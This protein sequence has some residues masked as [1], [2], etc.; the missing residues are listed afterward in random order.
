M[1]F[2]VSGNNGGMVVTPDFYLQERNK[3]NVGAGIIDSALSNEEYG[4]SISDTVE[5]MVAAQMGALIPEKQSAI[6]NANIQQ[7]ALSQFEATIAMLSKNTIKPL[8]QKNAL[9]SYEISNSNPN[10]IRAEISKTGA[11]GS[12]D[13]SIGLDQLAQSQSLK[14]SGFSSENDVL[15][16]GT[17]TIYFGQYDGG[18][19]TE[20]ANSGSITVEIKD[21]MTLRDLAGEINKLSK[22]IKAT[23]VTNSDGST[24]LALISQKTGQQNAMMV[25]TSGDPSLTTFDY[26]GIDSST[27]TQVRETADAIY[28][29]NGIQMTSDTN[30]I[31]D[32]FG[33]NL[34]LNEV[35]SGEVRIGTTVSPQG[36]I[37]NVYA[38]VENYNAMIDMYNSFNSKNPDEDFVGSINGSKVSDAI[39]DEINKLFSDGKSLKDIGVTRDPD[40]RLSLNQ[41]KLGA[42]LEL[43]PE[44]AYEILGTTTKSSHTGVNI[45]DLGNSVNG[46][47]TIVITRAPEKANLTG[48]ALVPNNTIAADTDLKLK[49][50]NKEVTIPI[51]AGDYTPGQLA[52]TINKE[53]NLAG[54]SGYKASIDGGALSINSAEYGSLKSIELLSDVPELGLVAQKVTGKD[55]AGTINGESFLGDGAEFESKFE[56]ASKGMKVTFDPE[57]ITLNQQITIST[58]KGFLD[59]LD[60]TI[61]NIKKSTTSEIKEIK[62]SLDKTRND[63]LVA[64]LEE[65]QNKEDYYY[66]MYYHQFSGISAAL[67]E[68]EGTIKMMEIMF[69]SD[70]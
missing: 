26:K 12:L 15:K 63:S 5:M 68:M 52:A 37:D 54:I 30:K 48:T 59:N 56:E 62:E 22:D 16:A 47:H 43:N 7:G 58:N 65:L 69:E 35:T 45:E 18:N 14:F 32:V 38:F 42:A 46:D 21:G 4:F 39:K 44:I 53:I 19:Y 2:T 49:L 25:T 20:N 61:S 13:L 60:S 66:N 70:K 34:T 17:F 3:G 55:V 33:L 51:S 23:I 27:A 29:V 40:G 6:T 50:G 41:D 57:K 8:N 64:Q 10:A 9:T 11:S 31:E 1:S 67:S 36:V 24:G 28:T